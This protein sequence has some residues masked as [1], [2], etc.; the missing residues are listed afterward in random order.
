M[1]LAN[2]GGRSRKLGLVPKENVKIDRYGL[3]DVDDFFRDDSA[4]ASA[5]GTASTS[6]AAPQQ[7]K[8]PQS[9]RQAEPVREQPFDNIARKINFNDEDEDETF[10]L[11]STTS[12]KKSPAVNKQS[13]LRSPLAEQDF[14]YNQFDDDMPGAN[15]IGVRTDD[16]EQSDIPD[17]NMQ[18]TQDDPVEVKGSP[19]RGKRATRSKAKARQSRASSSFTKKMALG[20]TKKLPSFSDDTS[21]ITEYNESRTEQEEDGEEAKDDSLEEYS[22]MLAGRSRVIK[23]SNL[24]SPP[25]ENT[26]GLRRSKRTRIKPLAFWRNERIIYTQDVNSD[27]DFDNTLARDI[28]NIPLR[29]IKEVVH[30][31]DSNAASTKTSSTKKKLTRG[32]KR[33]GK[34]QSP[35]SDV[36]G[37]AEQDLLDEGEVEEDADEDLSGSEWLRDEDCLQLNV[38]DNGALK[39]RKIA[40]SQG[41]GTFKQQRGDSY[42]VA[43]LFDEDKDFCAGGML[44][45]PVDG[46]KPPVTVTGSTYMF[47]VINGTIRVTLNEDV[48]TVKNGCK[49]Q[50]PEGN[51]YSLRNVGKTQAY[52]FFVQVSKPEEV[53]D[54]W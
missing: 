1:Y 40:Y 41:G 39:K 22:E 45:L 25:P 3:E 29:L 47:N 36:D 38:K 54:T 34:P 13:P 17:F 35:S 8:P 48:F 16:D 6:T 7:H 14:D 26:T 12:N 9:T 11:S 2:L 10:N 27:E 53:E 19:R 18:D 21:S 42:K 32:R 49:L 44:E 5:S 50:I 30:I 52:L 33:V 23:E 46:F 37:G 51:E 4:S 43:T 20:K 15:E 31:P 28:H 24:P